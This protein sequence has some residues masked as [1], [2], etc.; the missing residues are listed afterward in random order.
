MSGFGA[1]ARRWGSLGAAAIASAGAVTSCNDGAG[2]GPG[3]DVGARSNDTAPRDDAGGAPRL[4]E[5]RA[6]SDHA[7]AYE[8][9]LPPEDGG[10]VDVRGGWGWSDRCWSSLEAGRLAAARARC[11]AGLGI[12]PAGSGPDGRGAR[13]SLLYNLGLVE[14]RSGNLIAA[15]RRIAESLALRPHD[16][17]EAALRRVGGVSC[18]PCGSQEDF[19]AAHRRGAVCCP[20]I[21]C[22]R[23][24]D[25]PHPRVCCRIPGGQLCGDEPRCSPEQRVEPR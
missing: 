13:P 24:A 11:S 3:H 4:T 6:P 23:D 16:E 1:L 22:E 9:D 17:V 20:V 25:C 19:D 12:A 5:A 14:E 2:D 10:F 7:A 8:G 15:R 18:D 21:G